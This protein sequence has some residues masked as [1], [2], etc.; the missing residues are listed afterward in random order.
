MTS[1]APVPLPAALAVEIEPFTDD[2]LDA[3]I[4]AIWAGEV[5]A[6]PAKVGNFE[7]T[8]EGRAEWAM[9]KLVEY[10]L[11]VRDIDAR[12]D[13]WVERIERNRA[14]EKRRWE[15]R[16]AVFDKVLERYAVLRRAANEKDATIHL[17]SG[18][19][20]TKKPKAPTVHIGNEEAF[21][22]WARTNLPPD[23]RDKVLVEVPKVYVSELRKLHVRV[24]EVPKNDDDPGGP[25]EMV[26]QWSRT[27]D[28]P[29][30]RVVGTYAEKPTVKP[31]VSPDLSR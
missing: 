9:R 4:D 22:R 1:T 15:A 11:R 14:E 3:A 29:W 16:A 26:V 5:D 30:K 19:V 17:P 2:E 25:T 23:E 18:T 12:H 20:S 28:G 8:D 27:G 10:S 21:A 13:D 31:T 24:Q 6:I 7:L